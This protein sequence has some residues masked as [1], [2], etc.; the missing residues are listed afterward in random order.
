MD[1][2]A[3]QEFSTPA[4]DSF[5]IW[6]GLAGNT[7]SVQDVSYAFGLI[8][9]KGDGSRLTV[10]AENKFGN[11]GGYTYYNGTGTLPAI[12]TQLV[13]TGTAAVAGGTH[14]IKYSARAVKGGKFANEAQLT[15]DLFQGT[16]TARAA[17]SVVAPDVYAQISGPAT[18]RVGDV[19]S[20]TVKLG[21]LGAGAATHVV[22][23]DTLLAGTL[24]AKQITMTIPT[25]VSGT[26]TTIVRQVPLVPSMAGKAL[27][28]R[29]EVAASYDTDL[30][31]NTAEVT[32]LVEKLKVFLPKL[33]R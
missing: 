29:V 32:T 14:V 17:G 11:R 4:T 10:G 1:W 20:Y 7:P 3:V 25:M 22:V 24:Q 18:A 23:T 28:Y 15:S 26:L 9:G 27:T 19:I 12:G 8:N 30:T 2:E 33:I 31:N 16:S 6:I 21:N 5:E 13:V